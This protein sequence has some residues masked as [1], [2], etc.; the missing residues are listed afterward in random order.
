MHFGFI[1]LVNILA[2]TYKEMTES[3]CTPFMYKYK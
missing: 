3:V 2:E 1:F